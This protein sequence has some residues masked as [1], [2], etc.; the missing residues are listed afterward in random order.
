MGVKNKW[1]K[2]LLESTDGF[3]ETVVDLLLFQIYLLGSAVGKS[4]TSK[5]VYKIFYEAHQELGQLNY[6]T[7]KL[8]INYLK[9]KG[10]LRSLKE[11]EITAAGRKKL[12]SLVPY[13]D[14]KRSWDGSLYLVTYDVPEQVKRL[15]DKLRDFLKT[16]GSGKLQESVW[17]TV[18]NPGQ[19]VK[20]FV[21][22]NN[23]EGSIIVSCVGKGG[24]IGQDSLAELV[25][26][27]FELESLNER[28][29]EFLAE[30]KNEK[31]NKFK[32]AVGFYS[33]LKDDPQLPW[34]LLPDDWLGDK[35]HQLFKDQIGKISK[36]DY[37][38]N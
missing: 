35:A 36:Q 32:L 25:K 16:I 2:I 19:L 13:Y 29:R 10:F 34:E 33:I 38:S 37:R 27:V 22:E 12:T 1:K 5:D 21:R 6:R 14:K 26:K 4:K 7:I 20:E 23:L 18:Y 9:R 24:Y 17:L 15:R 8:T 11:P 3:L 28:Y 31:T 30:F